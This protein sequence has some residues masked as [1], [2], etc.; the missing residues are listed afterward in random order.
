MLFLGHAPDGRGGGWLYFPDFAHFLCFV[1]LGLV[2]SGIVL[3]FP[4]EQ[5]R[6]EEV[7]DLFKIKWL[8][9]DPVGTVFHG[10]NKILQNV[11]MQIGDLIIFSHLSLAVVVRQ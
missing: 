3:K 4:T 9:I 11:S 6:H 5:S 8:K 1:I 10:E 7:P 2:L